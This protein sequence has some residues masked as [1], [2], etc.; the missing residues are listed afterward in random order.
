[1]L[2][3]NVSS[4]F[5]I[6]RIEIHTII[7]DSHDAASLGTTFGMQCLQ[8]GQPRSLRR[9]PDDSGGFTGS[10]ESVGDRFGDQLS[11]LRLHL[12]AAGPAS[13]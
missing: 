4:T 3:E 10:S 5:F 2:S 12:T 6:P 9:P 1:M 8:W 13:W 7:I 11:N